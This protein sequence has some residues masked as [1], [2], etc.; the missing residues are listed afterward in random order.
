[1]S[2][3]GVAILVAVVTSQLLTGFQD[4]GGYSRLGAM[5]DRMAIWHST[6]SAPGT[7]TY[8]GVIHHSA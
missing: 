6:V 5:L 3:S 4:G 8:I 1:M 2:D 7:A